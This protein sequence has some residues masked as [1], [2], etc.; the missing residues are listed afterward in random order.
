MSRPLSKIVLMISAGTLLPFVIRAQEPAPAAKNA[1]KSAAKPAG[2]EAS[3]AQA[4]SETPKAKSD[5]I[6]RIKETNTN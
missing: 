5:P 3:R 2:K 6:E 4:K 1:E